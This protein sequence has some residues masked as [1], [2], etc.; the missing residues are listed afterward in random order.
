MV[1]WAKLKG[2]GAERAGYRVHVVTLETELHSLLA[3]IRDVGGKVAFIPEGKQHAIEYEVH[4]EGSD[5]LYWAG[6]SDGKELHPELARRL[7]E[8]ALEMAEAMARVNRITN[9]MCEEVRRA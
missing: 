3:K 6:A 9:A 1:D 8:L 7:M 4:P 2:L 5:S